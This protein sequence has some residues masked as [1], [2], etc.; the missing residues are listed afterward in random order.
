MRRAHCR[1]AALWAEKPG[2]RE[3]HDADHLAIRR[4]DCVGARLFVSV[5]GRHPRV[6]RLASRVEHHRVSRY[7]LHVARLFLQNKAM[8]AISARSVAL[9]QCLCPVMTALFSFL[10]LGER[11]SA[12][13]ILGSALLLIA[14]VAATLLR[15]E[16]PAERIRKS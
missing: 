9:L 6:E 3:R 4:G 10:L 15:S 8:C 14:L 16:T 2:L 7:P 1:L 11:L 13:G 5:R 12:A